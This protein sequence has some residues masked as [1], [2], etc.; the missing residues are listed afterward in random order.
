MARPSEFKEEYITKVDEYLSQ[1]QDEEV[2]IVKSAKVSKTSDESS[3]W[4]NV[5]IKLK[6]KLPTIEGFA[7]FIGVNKTSLYEWE[8]KHYKFSN[9]LD[10]IRT[11]QLQRLINMGL[12]GDYNSTIAKLMLSSNH[13]MREKSDL[14]SD[15]K[16]IADSLIGIIRQ[17]LEDDE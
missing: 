9:A 17:G 11:E 5:G 14:T 13:N 15:D 4:Q 8:K 12:S 3:G 16:P 6:V 2:K 1:N 7:M 10:K